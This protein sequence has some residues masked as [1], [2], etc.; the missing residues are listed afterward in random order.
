MPPRKNNKKIGVDAIVGP[1]DAAYALN[2]SDV[3]LSTQTLSKD[4]K[5]D[6]VGQHS[7]I[8]IPDEEIMHKNRMKKFKKLEASK[9]KKDTSTFRKMEE[10]NRN[11]RN[12]LLSE[13]DKND[14]QID[15]KKIL[16]DAEEDIGS[17]NTCCYCGAETDESC[18]CD[19]CDVYVCNDDYDY[20]RIECAH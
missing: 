9:K 2:S 16:N 8:E 6:Y 4:R 17:K 11:L 1:N 3:F 5:N 7:E 10:S 14:Q 18:Y 19:G 20:H 13:E 15:Q 12:I